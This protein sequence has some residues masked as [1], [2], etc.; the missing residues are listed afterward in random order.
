MTIIF[1][2]LIKHYLKLEILIDILIK[3]IE[4]EQST[5]KNRDYLI[6]GSDILS[7]GRSTIQLPESLAY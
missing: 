5:R 2:G 3:E 4:P 6:T 1:N 7:I